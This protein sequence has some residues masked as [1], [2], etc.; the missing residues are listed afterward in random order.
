VS[1]SLEFFAAGQPGRPASEPTSGGGAGW[2]AAD[3]C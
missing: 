2:E 1:T 3:D